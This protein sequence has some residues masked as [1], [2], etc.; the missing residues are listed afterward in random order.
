[1]TRR[2]VGVRARPPTW[3]CCSRAPCGAP[4]SLRRAVGFHVRERPSHDLCPPLLPRRPCRQVVVDAPSQQPR[5]GDR[6]STGVS[7]PSENAPPVDGQG[8]RLVDRRQCAGLGPDALATSP[9]LHCAGQATFADG[10]DDRGRRRPGRLAAQRAQ[11]HIAVLGDARCRHGR[12]ALVCSRQR[13]WP[14]ARSSRHPAMPRTI[15]RRP[16]LRSMTRGAIGGG[17]SPPRLETRVCTPSCSSCRMEPS[18][19]PPRGPTHAES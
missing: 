14:T 17:G 11:H 8:P 4:S 2:R 19:T 5:A 6:S 10:R 12:P 15:C 3:P 1:M 13:R 7:R 18:T 16:S 9:D